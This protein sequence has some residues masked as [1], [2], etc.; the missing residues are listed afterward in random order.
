MTKS[1]PISAKDLLDELA[2]DPE[3]LARVRQR[4]ELIQRQAEQLA[5]AEKPLVNAL[6][7]AGGGVSSVWDLVNSRQSYPHLVPVLLTHL[8]RSYPPRVREGIARALAVKEA[9]T[10][11]DKLV[12]SY[13]A[14]PPPNAGEEVN[15]VKWA[16]HLAI[17]RAAD[18]SVL[19]ELIGLVADRRHGAHRAYF[20]DALAG[21]RDPRAQAA[22]EE[23]KGDPDL[24]DNFKSLAKKKRL[25]E[26]HHFS[27]V[28]W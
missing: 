18:V 26:L 16:I 27:H 13:L 21:I 10:G 2:K 24:A 5:R 8:G 25:R 6:N 28:Q 9:R 11:W 23:L 14:E 22:L 19:D 20:V 1:K 4:D 3:H 15:E 17:A 12:R 7:S